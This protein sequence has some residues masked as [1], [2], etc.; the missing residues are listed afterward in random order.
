MIFFA[1]EC[2]GRVYAFDENKNQIINEQGTLYNYTSKHVA[3][4]RGEN[5]YLFD[6]RGK[7]VMQYPKDYIDISNIIGEKL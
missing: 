1:R 3:I 2:N 4:K 5:Y 6:E 7:N